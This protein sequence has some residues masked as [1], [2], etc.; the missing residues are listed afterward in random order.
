M[1]TVLVLIVTRAHSQLAKMGACELERISVDLEYL[2]QTEELLFQQESHL[3]GAWSGCLCLMYG[4]GPGRVDPCKAPGEV[5][6]Q[7]E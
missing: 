1:M 2:L 7:H 4:G 3:A 5:A 6:P